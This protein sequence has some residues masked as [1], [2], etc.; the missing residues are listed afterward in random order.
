[1]GMPVVRRL[2]VVGAIAASIGLSVLAGPAAAQDSP[3]DRARMALRAGRLWPAE[4]AA[5]EAVA[6][7]PKSAEARQLLGRVLARR[8]HW[9][10]AIASFE[11]ARSLDPELADLDRDLG[12]AHFAREEYAAAAGPL[13]R[14][15]AREPDQGVLSL[16]L[17]LC[18]LA[19]G[20]FDAA[21]TAFERASHDPVV[22]QVAL[23]HLGIARERAG[24]RDQARDAFERAVF[25]DPPSP[26][27]SRAWTQ[28]RALDR[29][30]GERPWSL[31]AGAG[32]VFDNNVTRQEIDVQ[33]DDPDGA[34][35]F[36][37][38]ASYLLPNV[39][40]PALEL[41]YDFQQTLYFD[42]SELDLQSHGLSVEAS[43]R[44]G[45]ADLSLS[46]LFSL[47]TLDG[48]RFVDFHEVRPTAGFAPTESWYASISPAVQITR[49]DEESR[50]DAE[51][52]SL[53]TLQI[54]ALGGW[55]RYVLFG[56]DGAIVD[57]SGSEFDRREVAAQTAL[58][59]SWDLGERQVPLDLRYRFRFRDY[60][61]DTPSIDEEREDTIHSLLLRAEVPLAGRFSLRFEY[62][63]ED[64]DSNLSSADYTDNVLS[65]MLRFSM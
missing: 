59:W 9:D 57:A 11:T 24:S 25:L 39:R 65:A 50:R 20:E 43:E 62:E 51:R 45:P 5:R 1:M 38:E 6:A 23:Y 58:H 52:F 12:R 30:E 44:V 37:L 42:V 48:D 31:A 46:Y 47:N 26:I 55:H 4:K 15:A 14:A 40:G 36:E 35:R 60:T 33:T 16:E 32:L 21:A 61:D 34:G 17:G 56:L 49:F 22:A 53:G 54:F 10:E 19:L 29:S 64:S 3:E 63:F 13:R 27:A 18:E 8:L 41:G 7:S 28:A 2:A